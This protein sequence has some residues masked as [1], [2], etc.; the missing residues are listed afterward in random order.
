MATCRAG[1]PSTS[2]AAAARPAPATARSRSTCSS[3]PTSTSPARSAGARCP[4]DPRGPLQGPHHRRRARHVGR[5][6]PGAVHQH[7][8]DRPPPGHP[9][10]RRPRL[11]Q[12]RPARSD[13]GPGAQR[14]KLA[15]ELAKRATGRTLYVLDEP[16]TGLH[17]EDVS[18]L[19]GVLHRLVDAGNSVIVIEHNLDVVKTADWVIDL[20]PEGGYRAARSSPRAPERVARTKGS[21]TGQFL[22]DAL[23]VEPEAASPP[24]GRQSLTPQHATPLRRRRPAPRPWPGRPRRPPWSCAG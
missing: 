10:R 2:A 15:S 16:T 14:V 13:P 5:G 1:S 22:T 3:R 17:F 18:K 9:Q 7:P 12:A 6:G 21:Y 20:G 11:H 8:A 4:R 23:G 24:V 19:P